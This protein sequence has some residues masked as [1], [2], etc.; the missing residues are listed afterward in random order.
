MQTISRSGEVFEQTCIRVP[1]ELKT[2]AKAAGISMSGTLREALEEKL[3]ET[4]NRNHPAQTHQDQNGGAASQG[5]A[6]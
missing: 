6:A 5:G 1:L 3:A 2:K 4:E